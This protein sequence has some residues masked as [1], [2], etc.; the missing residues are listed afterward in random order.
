[1]QLRLASS[2]YFPICLICF[3]L[4][5]NIKPQI[6]HHTA[7]LIVR[8][9]RDLRQVYATPGFTASTCNLYTA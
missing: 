5:H 8:D 4:I 2:S 7:S 1:M 6:I 3:I 9:N